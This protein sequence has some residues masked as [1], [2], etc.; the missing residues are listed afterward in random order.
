MSHDDAVALLRSERLVAIL[1]RVP[2]QR[3]LPGAH[4]LYDGGVHPWTVTGAACA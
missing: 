2:A 3:L 1:R 4:A